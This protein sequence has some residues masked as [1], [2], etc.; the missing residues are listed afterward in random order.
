MPT[1]VLRVLSV[2]FLFTK[3]CVQRERE[4]GVH[5][6]IAFSSRNENI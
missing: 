3:S 4:V 5:V 1:C 6:C 2:N